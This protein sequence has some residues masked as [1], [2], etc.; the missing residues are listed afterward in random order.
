MDSDYFQNIKVQPNP[1]T[2][3]VIVE[4]NEKIKSISVMTLNGVLIL[5]NQKQKEV[6]LVG[7]PS[8][9]Y[10]LDIVTDNARKTI[11]VVKE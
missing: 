4:S 5:E 3:K 1:T 7:L 10:F 11:K 8:G 2:D 9:M 6:S